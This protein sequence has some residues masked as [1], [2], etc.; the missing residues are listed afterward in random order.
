MPTELKSKSIRIRLS[1]FLNRASEAAQVVLMISAVAITAVHL[2]SIFA[3]AMAEAFAWFP[4][5]AFVCVI[6]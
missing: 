5:A 2:S 3:P 4:E 1:L 6:P